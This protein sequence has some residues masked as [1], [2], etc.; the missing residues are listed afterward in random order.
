MKEASSSSQFRL[1]EIL[2]TI[3]FS[4]IFQEKI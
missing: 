3:F 2:L 1:V 4:S